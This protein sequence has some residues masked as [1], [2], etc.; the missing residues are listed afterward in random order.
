MPNLFPS[1]TKGKV[2]FSA[3]GTQERDISARLPKS[4]EEWQRPIFAGSLKAKHLGLLTA[5]LFK[6][7]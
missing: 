3:G 1:S 2:A 5:P 4:F 7:L 6:L